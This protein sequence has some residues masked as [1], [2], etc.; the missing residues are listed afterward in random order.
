MTAKMVLQHRSLTFRPKIGFS[1]DSRS[2]SIDCET[3][4]LPS[5]DRFLDTHVPPISPPGIQM[6]A[7]LHW[8]RLCDELVSWLPPEYRSLYK[9][10]GSYAYHNNIVAIGSGTGRVIFLHFS[11]EKLSQYLRTRP[12]GLSSFRPE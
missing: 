2:V 7:K 4:P 9:F 11:F 3:L 8:I 6:H 1:S 5:E 12:K 10:R